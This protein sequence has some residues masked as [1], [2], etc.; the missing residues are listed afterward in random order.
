EQIERLELRGL[1]QAAAR[2]LIKRREEAALELLLKLLPAEDEDAETDLYYGLEA[3]G[4]T[5]GKVA[6]L[7][8]QALKDRAP[9]RRAVAACIVG[10]RGDDK[11]RAAVRKLL[12]DP[13]PLVR[14]RGAQGLLAS[15]DKGGLPALIALLSE[16]DVVIS[17][18]AE[19]LL[20][21]AAGDTSPEAVVGSATA[22]VRR[23]C[24]TAWEAWH[25]K[26][27]AALD[28]AERGKDG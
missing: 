25:R 23:R 26:H 19:E 20:H 17:W 18:Q 13:S 3:L 10:W 6:P 27:A 16:P 14:L 12:D 1:E 24:R 9:E 4:V 5:R 15:R 22:E 21:W 11:Q 7:L 28:L 2:L 8:I